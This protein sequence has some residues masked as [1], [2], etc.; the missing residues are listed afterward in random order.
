MADKA[1]LSFSN[2]PYHPRSCRR[3]RNSSG[4]KVMAERAVWWERGSGDNARRVDC[5]S[6]KRERRGSFGY[7]TEAV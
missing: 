4:G 2:W 3:N 6:G 1:P 7:A 5:P